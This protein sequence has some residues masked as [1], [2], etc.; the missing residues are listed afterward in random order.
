MTYK[1]GRAIPLSAAWCA[2]CVWLARRQE[3]LRGTDT[4]A[5]AKNAA[6]FTE[7]P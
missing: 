1:A 7:Q 6:T 2:L 4:P 3:T 5:P